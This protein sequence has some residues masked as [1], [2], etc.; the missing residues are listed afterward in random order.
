[1]L[2][3]CFSS[4]KSFKRILNIK[5]YHNFN[6][7]H[8]NTFGLQKD[9]ISRLFMDSLI[10]NSFILHISKILLDSNMNLTI[11]VYA[12]KCLLMLLTRKLAI[13][14]VSVMQGIFM[15]K[16]KKSLIMIINY[17]NSNY[18]TRLFLIYSLT[19]IFKLNFVP[20]FRSINDISNSKRS[21]DDF[22]MKKQ[23][24]YLIKSGKLTYLFILS[25]INI[26]C[27]IQ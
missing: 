23:W 10:S 7:Y 1:M 24:N 20:Y 26:N 6:E 11:K 19:L 16:F 22:Y 12:I 27:F 4:F 25:K 8:D 21:K 13:P 15:S 17:R 5:H 2:A 3:S 18:L 14:A 9:V